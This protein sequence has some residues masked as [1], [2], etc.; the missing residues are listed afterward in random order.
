M[1][2]CTAPDTWSR[3]SDVG[4]RGVPSGFVRLFSSFRTRYCTL[5]GVAHVVDGTSHSGDRAP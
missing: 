5:R 4:V 3:H 2:V 1:A